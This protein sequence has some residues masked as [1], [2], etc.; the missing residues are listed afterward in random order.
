MITDEQVYAAFPRKV[1]KLAALSA[2]KRAV[3]RESKAL[4]EAGAR[5]MIYEATL[6]FAASPAGNKGMFTP[7]PATFF[8]QGR[9]HDDPSEWWADVP[10]GTIREPGIY[11]GP[12][13]ELSDEEIRA[14]RSRVM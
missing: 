1:A 6:A 7:H 4:G 14:I 10:R 3:I 13:S 8:N 5:K 9:Y 2:I 12:T 11:R